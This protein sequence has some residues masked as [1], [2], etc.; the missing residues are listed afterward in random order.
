MNALTVV[1]VGLVGAVAGLV[2]AWAGMAAGVVV[3]ALLGVGGGAV[4]AVRERTRADEAIRG[5]PVDV[6]DASLRGWP[7]LEQAMQRVAGALDTQQELL[8]RE[9]RW[10]DD[11]VHSL[12]DAALVFDA[13]G[14]LI[15][16]N[17]G[18][19]ELLALAER[20]MTTVVQA[21]GS[22]PLVD[23]VARA[24]SQR[25]HVEADADIR[26]R[27]VRASV[28]TIGSETLVIITDRTQERRT[29]ELRRNFV[30]NASHELKTPAT[31]IHTLSEALEITAT[32][33]PARIPDLVARLHEE[34]ER[35]VRLV[36]DLLNLRRLEERP[37]LDATAVD[38]A[39]VA[40]EVLAD[41]DERAGARGI[42]L[43]LH[44][45]EHAELE[46]EAD[47]VRLIV[48]NLVANAIQY[49]RDGGRVDVR[50]LPATSTPGAA[51]T[52][53]VADTGIGIPQQDL[54]RIFERF[55][56][57][58]VARSRQTGGTGLGLSI[59]RHAVERHHGTIRV[60]SLLGEGT[61]FSVGLPAT[62]PA[63]N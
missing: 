58:D 25:G 36:H 62:A 34:A 13:Q 19:R 40:A 60:D 47:D 30:V 7:A 3:G 15:A 42:A 54:Q 49:N 6:R 63:A 41:L 38:L 45:P 28:A 2:G 46:G 21:L 11:L 57:V 61:T 24:R 31:A 27:H 33:D 5:L 44:A 18:A 4:V 43:S 56:R 50:I 37:V 59:V 1:L 10:R 39:A 53:E 8:D 51:W 35:L 14:Y 22:R 20:P 52:L 26:D 12:V 23:A 48:R 16:A 9:R 17:R 29:E 55:Y 32:R